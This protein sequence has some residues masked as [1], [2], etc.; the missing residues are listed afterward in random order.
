V[1]L[2]VSLVEEEALGVSVGWGIGFN[3]GSL[4]VVLAPFHFLGVIS[5][6]LK[7]LVAFP[8]VEFQSAGSQIDFG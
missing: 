4:V 5:A 8:Y 2:E 7:P 6:T 1:G 3:E